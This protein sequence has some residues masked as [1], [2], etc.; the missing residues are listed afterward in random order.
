M[1]RREFT[2]PRKLQPGDTVAVL[3]PS[4]A[5]PAV[6]PDVF[7][8]GLRRLREEFGLVPVEY[9]TTRK[10]AAS[11]EHRRLPPGRSDGAAGAR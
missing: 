2:Y 7:E 10:L 1:T 3:S 6:F 8:L 4:W 9:P 11:D 5:G